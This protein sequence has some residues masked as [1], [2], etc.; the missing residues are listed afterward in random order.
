MVLVN[1]QAREITAKIVYY[2]PGLCGKTTNLYAIH[3]KLAEK[4]RGNLAE[5]NT[6]T[7]RTLFFDLLPVDMGL[8]AG[9]KVKLQVYTVPGQVFYNSTRKIVLRGADAVVFVADSQVG[10]LA[11][12]KES[13]ENLAENLASNGID[14]T[15]IPMV[16]QW[17]KRDLENIYPVDVLERELN[18]SGKLTFEA[19]ATTGMG[20]METLRGV[21]DLALAKTR[22]EL[23]G[24][25]VNQASAAN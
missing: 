19:S 16:F 24:E 8:I 7:E 20:V 14:P 23:L 1:Q 10:K 15:T 4:Q 11:E 9:C 5:F 22:A 25:P 12:N 6:Q 21:A 17:N 18:T 3:K 2:G 13:Y